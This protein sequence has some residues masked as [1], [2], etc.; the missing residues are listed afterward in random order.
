M[1]KPISDAQRPSGDSA[2]A[3]PARLSSLN[4]VRS[5]PS[6]PDLAGTRRTRCGGTHRPTRRGWIPVSMLAFCLALLA[7]CSGENGNSDASSAI[8]ATRGPSPTASTSHTPTSTASATVI[9]TRAPEFNFD[10]IGNLVRENPGQPAASWFLVYEQAGAP[11]LTVELRFDAATQCVTSAQSSGC[12]ALQV[13][14]RVAVLGVRSGDAVR[15][16]RL[17]VLR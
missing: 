6:E 2:R 10:R 7:G 11:A 14:S 9:T 3:E 1:E 8:V 5:T 16:V 17:E 15:V 12:D 4:R 13:G